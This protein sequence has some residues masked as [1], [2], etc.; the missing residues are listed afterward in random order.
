MEAILH[1]QV[2]AG[3]AIKMTGKRG[4]IIGGKLRSGEEIFAKEIG[5]PL[6]T[7]TDI[8]VGVAPTVREELNKLNEEIEKM[9][10]KIYQVK[11]GISRLSALDKELTE[12]E[13]DMLSKYLRAESVLAERIKDMAARISILSRKIEYGK[14]GRV[15]VLGDIHPGVRITIGSV[16]DYIRERTANVSFILEGET[17]KSYQ[18]T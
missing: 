18:I 1:S 4:I 8:E 5:S 7:L 11:V 13:Q 15:K 17:I 14:D 3:R 16:V 2:S 12:D 6:S 9:K 10:Q